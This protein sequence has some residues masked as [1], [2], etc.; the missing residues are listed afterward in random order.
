MD[1][2]RAEIEVNRLLRRTAAAAGVSED[3]RVK[4]V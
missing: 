4:K 1:V 3:R 2:A